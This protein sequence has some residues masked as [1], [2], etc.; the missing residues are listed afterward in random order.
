MIKA[1]VLT[2]STTRSGKNNESGRVIKSLLKEN[3]IEVIKKE[4]VTDSKRLIRKKLIDYASSGEID[5][6]ITTGGTGLGP[7]DFTPEATRDVI[8]K[9]APGL[10]ELIR[11]EGIKFTKRAALSGGVCGVKNM[12]LIIN[13]P[14]SPKGVRQSL[15][16]VAGLLGHAVDI[17]H[18]GGH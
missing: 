4:L 13:L 7:Y 11:S 6:V 18:G 8:E 2:V 1:A 17:I 12:T 16:A 10:A 5:I 3:G 15:E 14:G 9:E